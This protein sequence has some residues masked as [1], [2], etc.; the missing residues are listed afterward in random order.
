MDSQ[1]MVR[2]DAALNTELCSGTKEGTKI[3]KYTTI[4]SFIYYYLQ[5]FQLQ[6]KVYCVHS[7]GWGTIFVTS[8]V[9]KDKA[10]KM[11]H[12]ISLNG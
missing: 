5:Y 11:K 2:H 10:S 4:C 12:V 3:M 8:F 9:T 7:K 6:L 1:H